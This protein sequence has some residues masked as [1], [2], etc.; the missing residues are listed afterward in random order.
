MLQIETH[1]TW[2][3]R[4]TPPKTK[5]FKSL[6]MSPFSLVQ[7]LIQ[8][9][10]SAEPVAA[11]ITIVCFLLYKS[12]HNLGLISIMSLNSRSFSKVCPDC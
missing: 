2:L 4:D 1:R 9:I 3:G 8:L 11:L 5:K 10:S 7:V 12:M 6:N